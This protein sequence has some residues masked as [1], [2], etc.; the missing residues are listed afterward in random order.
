MAFIFGGKTGETP[1]TLRRKRSLAEALA[2]KTSSAP[3]NVGEGLNAVGNA[4][5]YRALMGKIDAGEA[6]GKKA[7]EVDRAAFMGGF[8]ASPAPAGASSSI[9]PMTDA[10]GEVSSTSPKVAASG[11][12]NVYDDFISGVKAAGLTNPYGLAAVAATG[13]AESGWSPQ[14]ANRSWSDPSQ[15]GQAGTAGGVMSWRN[16]RLNN[17]YSFARQRG[18]QPGHISPA[19]QA[20]F[21]VQEDPSLIQSLNSAK[22]AEEAQRL[23]NN[24]WKFA[25]YDKPDGETARRMGLASSYLPRFQGGATEVASLDPSAGMSASQAI[26]AAAAPSGYVD[27]MVSAPNSR[28][29]VANALMSSPPQSEQVSLPGELS[30]TTNAAR[31]PYQGVTVAQALGSGP[32]VQ[33]AFKLLNNPYA[34]DADK[35][36]ATAV[37]EQAQ[38]RNDPS[39]QLEQDYRRAQLEALREKPAKTWQKLDDTTLFNPET[40]ETQRVNATE[41]GN[42]Q[43]RFKGNSVDAQALNGLM[44]A[45]QLTPD[46]AQQI[47]AGKTVTGPNGEIIFMTPQ[48]VFGQSADGTV[49]PMSAPQAPIPPASAQ[50]PSGIDIFGTD[51]PT[52]PAPPQ[53]PQP[54]AVP[55]RQGMIPLTEPKVTIDESKAGGFADRMTQSGSLIDQFGNA[56]LSTFDQTIT[57]SP[58]VPGFIANNLVGD[59]FQQYDQARR[60]FINA[61][62]RR[63]SG[64]VISPEEFDNANKQYFPQPGDKPEVLEQKRKNRETV[65]GAMIRDAGPTYKRPTPEG[66]APKTVKSQSEY[67]ALPS[68]AEFIAPDGSRRRKP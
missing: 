57:N 56:G 15:S 26:D 32:S 38:K 58:Y 42:G 47:A 40:G 17:L 30:S 64:A 27:P 54:P 10:A 36:M 43:F 31:Q 4:L 50:A 13:Q 35:A 3:R 18:E 39:Y 19:T 63:E 7:L 37:I 34:T 51:A 22:S 24:A 53:A 62:L 20:A 5:I 28:G 65:I 1:E 48:G 66:S 9:V 33:Q 25:G 12:G 2:V 61:Q 55:Q 59:D 6:D 46:Q 60:D 67:E 49:S 14:N 44:D 52:P 68:G 8:G 45:G 29:A 16:E 23:M 41:A 11:S 21:F